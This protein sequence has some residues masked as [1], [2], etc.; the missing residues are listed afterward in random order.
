M[1][2]SVFLPFHVRSH[3]DVFSPGVEFAGRRESLLL[4]AVTV[5]FRHGYIHDTPLYVSLRELKLTSLD[6]RAAYHNVATARVRVSEVIKF[7]SPGSLTIGDGWTQDIDN[8]S[9]AS[10][11]YVA[12]G[13]DIVFVESCEG[14]HD[15]RSDF[16]RTWF[17]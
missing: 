6:V 3:V 11:S 13:G 17:G 10:A 8:A 14:K 12:E 7:S 16:D 1:A 15:Y 9:S 5:C 2:H 4:K